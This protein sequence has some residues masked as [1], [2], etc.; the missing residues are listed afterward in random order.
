MAIHPRAIQLLD[1]WGYTPEQIAKDNDLNL[2]EVLANDFYKPGVITIPLYDEM[3]SE[4][5]KVEYIK[6]VGGKDEVITP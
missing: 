4:A 6:I 5:L 2:E 1:S 3:V